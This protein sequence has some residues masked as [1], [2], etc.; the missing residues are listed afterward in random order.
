ME[1][2]MAEKQWFNV[3]HYESSAFADDLDVFVN[4]E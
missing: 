4:T 2:E 1:N 3:A